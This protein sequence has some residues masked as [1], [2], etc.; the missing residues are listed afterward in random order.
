MNVYIKW[1]EYFR[2][3]WICGETKD[4]LNLNGA[5]EISLTKIKLFKQNLNEWDALV[6]QFRIRS[7]VSS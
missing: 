4:I 1:S 7:A 2:L 3:Q 5:A 6:M